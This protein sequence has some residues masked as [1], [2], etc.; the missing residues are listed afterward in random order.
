MGG[1]HHSSPPPLCPRADGE[2]Y[3]GTMNNFQG[4]EPIISR[5]LGTRTLLKTD[6]FLRWLSGEQREG[7]GEDPPVPGVPAAPPTPA[8][9]PPALAVPVADAAFVASFSIPGDDKVYFF[10]EETADEFDFFERLLVP[11]VARVCKVGAGMTAGNDAGL[12][13]GYTRAT[14][15]IPSDGG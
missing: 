1:P 5:S 3:A 10:F 15:G 4:N 12:Q 9:H 14:G 11:R 7:P 8:S 13:W 2:L 6:A